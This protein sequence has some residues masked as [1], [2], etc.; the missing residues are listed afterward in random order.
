MVVGAAMLAV[1]VASAIY[2]GMSSASAAKAQARQAADWA[3]YNAAM[4][5]S[6]G[7]RNAKASIAFATFNAGLQRMGATAEAAALQARAKYNAGIRLQIAEYNAKQIEQEVPLIW[8]QAELDTFNLGQQIDAISGANRAAYGASGVALDIGTPVDVETDI[9]TQEALEAFVVRHNA[10]IAT[11]RIV[12]AAAKSRWEGQ[13]EAATILHEG[14]VQGSLAM[15]RGNLG[16]MGTLM[17]GYYDASVG[18]Y[19]TAAKASGI[20]FQGSYQQNYYDDLAT[21]YYVDT[22]FNVGQT[23]VQWYAKNYTP[24]SPPENNPIYGYKPSALYAQNP[25]AY[26][27]ISGYGSSVLQ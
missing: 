11:A 9:R 2:Q 10:Q 23:A 5:R 3:A 7:E 8:D 4:A 1:T 27:A 20:E 15:V 6:V 26:R 18:R 25:A 19:N 24:G 21:K 14:T 22:A 13:V 16:A 12:D 17:Q